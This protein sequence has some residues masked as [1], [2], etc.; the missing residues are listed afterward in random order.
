MHR[1]PFSRLPPSPPRKED[2]ATRLAIPSL[3]PGSPPLPTRGLLQQSQVKLYGN[4]TDTWSL[5]V[6]KQ[7]LRSCPSPAGPF[8]P[9]RPPPLAWSYILTFFPGC[10]SVSTVTL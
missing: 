7:C 1:P 8:P 10:F 5:C 4:G 6:R 3:N 9:P 2:G